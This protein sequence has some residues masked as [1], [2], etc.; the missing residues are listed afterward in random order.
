MD[1]INAL[2]LFLRTAPPHQVGIHQVLLQNCQVI[3]PNNF[4]G[5]YRH[6]PSLSAGYTLKV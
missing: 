2:F 1:L 6:A 3:K 5:D 4:M